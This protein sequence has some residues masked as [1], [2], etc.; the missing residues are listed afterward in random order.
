MT[1]LGND[2]AR[3]AGRDP[4]GREAR[5]LAVFDLDGTL[6]DTPQAIVAAFTATLESLGV[7]VPDAAAIRAT[8]G[9]PLERALGD[10]LGVP[11]DE[12]LVARAVRRYRTHF[13][14]IILPRAA[15]LVFPR[16]AA[17]LDALRGAGVLLAVATSK[18]R[19]SADALLRAAGLHD[20]FA[21]VVGADEVANPKPHPEA[22]Q[23]LLAALGV[24][25][26][27]AV[28][29]GDTVHDIGMAHAAGMRSIAVTYGVQD[30]RLLAAARPTWTADTFDDVVAR[31][32]TAFRTTAKEVLTCPTG[33]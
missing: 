14:E 8:I 31:L 2:T 26:G 4:A 15:A 28:M 1:T 19:A 30:A 32:G 17:G 9:L 25:A 5:H 22:A 3:T 29:V 7:A 27:R 16:V 23:H 6:V 12:E 21:L 20:R 11:A 24:P 33:S 18:F 10:L 13:E